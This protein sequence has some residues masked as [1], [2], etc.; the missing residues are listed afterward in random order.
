MLKITNLVEHKHGKEIAAKE[1]FCLTHARTHTH[2]HTHKKLKST[3]DYELTSPPSPA[4]KMS[5]GTFDESKSEKSSSHL[6]LQ[7][8]KR[9]G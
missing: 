3:Q 6:P 1:E 4:E 5:M 2:T 8:T 9:S 7:L